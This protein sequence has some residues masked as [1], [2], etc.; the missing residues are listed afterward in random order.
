ME[1]AEK[2]I[3]RGRAIRLECLDC[4]GDSA[5]EVKRCSITACPLW[6]FRLGREVKEGRGACDG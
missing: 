2:R 4:V 5:S 6:P 3:T 1:K